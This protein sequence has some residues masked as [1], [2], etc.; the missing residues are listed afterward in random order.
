MKLSIQVLHNNQCTFWRSDWALL[1]SLIKEGKI[2]ADFEEVLIDTDEKA[3]QYRFF[4][5]PQVNINGV[6]VDPMAAQMTNF[7]WTGCRP[8]FYKNQTYD[9]APEAMIMEAVGRLK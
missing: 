2:D 5:S 4:G 9:Y 6:D 8:Y 3:K 7:H 1:E